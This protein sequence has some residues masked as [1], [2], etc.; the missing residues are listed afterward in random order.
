MSRAIGDFAFKTNPTLPPE[1]QMVTGPCPGITV[2][3]ERCARTLAQ[4]QRAPGS[5]VRVRWPGAAPV[6]PDVI[7]ETISEEDEFVILACDGTGHASRSAN[8]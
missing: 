2:I 5:V 6:N 1:E 4:P 3:V 7:E 8:L